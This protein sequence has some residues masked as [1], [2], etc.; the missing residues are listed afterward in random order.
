[1]EW[2]QQLQAVAEPTLEDKV[3]AALE[4]FI[5]NLSAGLVIWSVMAIWL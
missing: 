5:W 4:T 3:Y 2:L 1:M